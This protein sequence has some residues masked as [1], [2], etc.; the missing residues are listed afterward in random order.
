[1]VVAIHA[2]L[3]G[4][5]QLSA[6]EASLVESFAGAA[7]VLDNLNTRILTGAE[8]NNAMVAMHAA[9]ISA[10]VRVAAK[11]GTARRAKPIPGLHD[12]GGLLEQLQYG[13]EEVGDGAD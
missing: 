12:S 11:L 4:R 7:V 13:S 3:G 1:L 10:Q 2:D 8:I 6:I 9:A 5:D